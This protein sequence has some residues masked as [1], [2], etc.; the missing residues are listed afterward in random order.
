MHHL[1]CKFKQLVHVQ[2]GK[3]PTTDGIYILARTETSVIE[4][5]QVLTTALLNLHAKFLI[6]VGFM[7][8]HRNLS[9]LF[10]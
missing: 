4:L 7:K 6:C 8:K 10:F 5:F 9:Y 1:L 2:T 3:H